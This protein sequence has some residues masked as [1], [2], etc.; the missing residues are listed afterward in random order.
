MSKDLQTS[1]LAW[2]KLRRLV[3]KPTLSTTAVPSD[4]RG[5]KPE[6]LVFPVVHTPYDYKEV[7]LNGKHRYRCE[8]DD[9]GHVR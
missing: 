8:Y 7:F 9:E 6:A 1:K 4:L 3:G 5:I 2:P